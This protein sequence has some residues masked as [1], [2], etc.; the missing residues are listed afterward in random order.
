M[1]KE[2]V[3]IEISELENLIMIAHSRALN[4]MHL[5]LRDELMFMR[6]ASEG[7]AKLVKHLTGKETFTEQEL[8]SARIAEMIA[9]E[10]AKSSR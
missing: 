4:E 10:I 9:S 5:D 2:V 8:R 3:A 6:I 1:N 7:N